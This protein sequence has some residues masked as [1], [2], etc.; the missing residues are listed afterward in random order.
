MKESRFIASADMVRA[1]GPVT[2][3]ELE[4]LRE[5]RAKETPVLEL[6][7]GGATERIIRRFEH[8]RRTVRESYIENRLERMEGRAGNDFARARIRGKAKQ[9]FDRER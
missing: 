6:T 9:D 2:R 5:T 4:H 7:P 3:R 8:E 1:I